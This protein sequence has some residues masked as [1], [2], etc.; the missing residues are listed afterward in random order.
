MRNKLIRKYP[1][2][3][4]TFFDKRTGELLGSPDS[5]ILRGELITP[6]LL[7]KTLSK[8]IL[9]VSG[10][11]AILAFSSDEN[12]CTPYVTDED[13]VICALSAAAFFRFL[14]KTNA[15]IL[16]GRDA[17]P[18]GA[19]LAEAALR[20]LDGE[21]AEIE[22]IAT[23]SAPEIMAYSNSGFNGFFY[24][25][26]SHNPVGHNGFKFGYRGG[27]LNGNDV[28]EVENIFRSMLSSQTEID[29]IIEALRYSENEQSI[30]EKSFECKTAALSYYESFILKTAEETPEWL[31]NIGIVAEFNGS[32]RSSS[33]DI[34]FLR[35]LGLK[36]HAL[37]NVPGQIVHP[38]VPEGNNLELCR[39]T[40]EE[41]HRTDKDFIIGYVPDNDGDRGNLAYYSERNCRAEILAAQQVFA[42]IALI[43]VAHQSLRGDKK[44]AIAANGCTSYL[45]DSAIACFGASVF[46]ADVGEANVVGLAEELRE[47]GYSVK[48]AG[49]GSNGGIIE[50]PAKVRDPINSIMTI[51]K[52]YYVPGLYERLRKALRIK[53]KTPSLESVIEAMPPYTT[54]SAF[55]ANGVM[56][57][58]VADFD[59]FKSRYEKLFIDEA[60]ELMDKYGF[61]SYRVFQMEGKYEEEGIGE[62]HRKKPSTGGY[63]VEFF[64]ADERMAYIWLSKS[65]TEALIRIMADIKGDDG[66]LHD[67]LLFWQRSLIEKANHQ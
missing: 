12:D 18:T 41:K 56:H 34:P 7:K 42:L 40:L 64:K 23:S 65:R 6:E 37:N 30:I 55:S 22:Y 16:L 43:E 31:S 20:A 60:P 5:S 39:R 11:R 62:A 4:N 35:K 10:W 8:Y 28:K 57:I 50:Y 9:S 67:S 17:R 13:I 2:I 54:T 19:I 15:R 58:N 59:G 52:I 38:I 36:I 49:E 51:L 14:N 33:V 45:A 29:K 24:I 63:R 47:K 27:V 61:T 25:S 32:A 21:C 44:I 46:R 3:M 53:S 48:I 1:Q 26:A 66:D